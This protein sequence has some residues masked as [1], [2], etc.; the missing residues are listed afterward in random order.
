MPRPLKSILVP[1]L[2]AGT[3]LG[4]SGGLAQAAEPAPTPPPANWWDTITVSGSVDAGITFNPDSPPDGL[5]FGRLFTDKANT[6]LFNQFLLTVQRPLDPKATDYDF[7]FKLQGMY[8]T[9]ARYTH[10][11]GELDYII[12]DRAQLTPVE[13]WGIVHTPWLFSGGIDIKFG[14]FVTLEGAETIDPTTNYLYS[15]SYIFNFGIPFVDTGIM[16]ISHVDPMVDIYAGIVTGVNTTFGNGQGDNNGAPAFEGGIGLNLLGGNLT[17]LATTHIGPELPDTNGFNNTINEFVAC[18]CNP[19]GT[20]RYLNDITATWKVND[21]LTLITDL[22]YIHDDGT[23]GSIAGIGG[24]HPSGYGIAQYAIYKVADWLSLVGRAEVW[25]DTNNFF[26]AA[27]PGNFDFVNAEHGFLNTSFGGGPL[28]A[29]TTYLELTAGLN[30]SA[31]IPDGTPVLKG[32]TFRPEVRY[33][34][35]LNG[36]TPFDGGSGFFG[37]PGTP[38]FGVGTKSSQV[39]FG[40]DVIAKF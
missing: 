39:T 27:Y 7:G 9:D 6:P 8:G 32:L 28:G 5:N 38:G 12:N 17:I 10:Y 11:L 20:L 23:F 29:G 25:R 31:P 37:I 34:T 40:G 16:T 1:A 33:D 36:T 13:A 19:N 24:F 30:I 18:N 2:C 3:I 35:S 21:N 4:V 26:V 22:N 15:H 14:Q